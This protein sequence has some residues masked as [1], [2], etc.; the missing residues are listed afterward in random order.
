VKVVVYGAGV[1]GTVYAGKLAEAVHKVTM[2][3]RG[4]R[5][6]DISQNG[7]VLEDIVHR[8][9]STAQVA[10]AARL[11]SDDEYDLALITVRRDQL[12]SALPE[13]ATNKRIPTLLFMLNNPTG[14]AGLANTLGSD[15][16][17][18]GFP[19]VGGTRDGYVVRYAMIKQQPTTIGE[20]DA[21]RTVRLG[22][23]LQAFRDAGMPTVVCGDMD[24][25]L[26]AHAFFVTAVSGAIHLAGGDC[27][28][29]SRNS[30]ALGLMTNGVREGFTAVRALG[31]RIRPFSL[32][33]LFMWLPDAFA[34]GY[35]RRFL[36]TEMA[37][38]VFGRHARTAA[39]EM[40]DIAND[41]RSLV[42]RS[43]VRAPALLR[44][45]H[46]IDVYVGE[47]IRN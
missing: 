41:C 7:L 3:A 28:K 13:L 34:V 4:Q 37:D 24:A 25:W 35:W 40:R 2:I 23:I 22:T 10:T 12:A 11:N 17:M 42:E 16:V 32:N 31:H 29:L 8:R 33:L 39:R 26:K 19:G 30:A 6:A 14:S 5:L 27:G 15:R 1:M 44:L 45:Y 18:L 46:A 38:Y 36:A 43:G 9:G 21:R 47:T 20:P